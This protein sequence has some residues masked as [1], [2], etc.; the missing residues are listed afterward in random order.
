MEVFLK[1]RYEITKVEQIFVVGNSGKNFEI[2]L[3]KCLGLLV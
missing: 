2:I 1:L 3:V